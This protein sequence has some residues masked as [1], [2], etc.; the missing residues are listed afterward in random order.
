M[1]TSSALPTVG[2]QYDALTQ[3]QG[4][5]QGE[6]DILAVRAHGSLVGADG[7]D[8]L[9]DL[10]V[11]ITADDPQECAK[12]FTEM[13]TARLSPVFAHASSKRC[14]GMTLRLV[15]ADLRRI[16]AS[17]DFPPPEVCGAV[18]APSLPSA[19][20]TAIRSQFDNMLNDF[21]F[22]AVLAATKAGRG[23]MLIA[24]HLTHGLA[25]HILVGA[26][27][28]RDRDTGTRH[29]RHGGTLHDR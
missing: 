27:L 23:D 7:I 22:E 20:S 29:H 4:W 9:S 8:T 6:P 21:L 19:Q 3:I 2:W 12:R 1:S 14:D 18:P 24:A 26:M 11:T 13:V 16:D 28:M 25:R 5:A 17:I 10:D 15:L